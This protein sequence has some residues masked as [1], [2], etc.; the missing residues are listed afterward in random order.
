MKSLLQTILLALASFSALN[1]QAAEQK[2][3]PNSWEELIPAKTPFFGKATH[4]KP[5]TDGR[6]MLFPLACR[7]ER[8]LRTARIPG[9][10]EIYQIYTLLED[11]RLECHLSFTKAKGAQRQY[12]D[13]FEIEKNDA[14]ETIWVF[15]GSRGPFKLKIIHNLEER[16]LKLQAFIGERLHASSYAKSYT[17]TKCPGVWPILKKILF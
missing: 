15:K 8:V 9:K 10:P 5:G 12:L 4:H 11:G 16:S 3:F 2:E 7:N 1:T 6:T 13:R 17:I 14:N